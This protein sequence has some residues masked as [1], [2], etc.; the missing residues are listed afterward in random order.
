MYTFTGDAPILSLAIAVS[1]NCYI[2]IYFCKP[3]DSLLVA[4]MSDGVAHVRRRTLPLAAIA[5]EKA[6][7]KPRPGTVRYFL[8]GADAPSKKVSISSI[9]VN[10]AGRLRDSTR[11]LGRSGSRV[12]QNVE[13]VQTQGRS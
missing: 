3:D 1:Q 11:K 7:Q 8:R 12:Q 2:I 4:G 9:F 13:R 5:Q 6:K 10:C